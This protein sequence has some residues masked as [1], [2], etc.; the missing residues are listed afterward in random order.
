MYFQRMFWPEQP[1]DPEPHDHEQQQNVEII[2]AAHPESD[3]GPVRRRAPLV[4]HPDDQGHPQQGHPNEQGHPGLSHPNEQEHPRLSHPNEQG[5]P[6]LG[7][8]NHPRH[9]Q[10]REVDAVEAPQPRDVSK[11]YGS[12]GYPFKDPVIVSLIQSDS[13]IGSNQEVQALGSEIVTKYEDMVELREGVRDSLRE[14]KAALRLQQTAEL[15]ACFDVLKSDAGKGSVIEIVQ[16]DGEWR[17]DVD[18]ITLGMLKA[19]TQ[20]AVAQFNNLLRNARDFLNQKE[21]SLDFIRGKLEQMK[22]RC[23]YQVNITQYNQ[24]KDIP[25]E[26]CKL[27]EEIERFLHDMDIAKIQLK[28]NITGQIHTL[29]HSD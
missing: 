17:L 10:S 18:E 27:A 6:Q 25:A 3:P 28:G 7:Q 16:E 12:Q 1:P 8:P 21:E 11:P 5:H 23:H 22:E 2:A 4:D 26:I 15:P 13:R 24:V 20:R 29:P 14:F 9:P 19:P